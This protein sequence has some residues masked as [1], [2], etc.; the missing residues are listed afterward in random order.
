MSPNHS[1]KYKIL[2]KRLRAARKAA[3][4]TQAQAAH[5]V[6][7][8]QA[9]ISKMETNKRTIDPVELAELAEVYGQPVMF[10]LDFSEHHD[11]GE[12]GD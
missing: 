8:R 9:F 12:D 1:P 4:L 7:Q 3:G 5:R 6:G 11:G 10:F 2:L